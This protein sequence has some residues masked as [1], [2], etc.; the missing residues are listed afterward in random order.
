MASLVMLRK[1]ITLEWLGRRNVCDISTLNDWASFYFYFL[2]HP[3]FLKV[4]TY[5]YFLRDSLGSLLDQNQHFLKMFF[6][7]ILAK[8]RACQNSRKSRK[9][10]HPTTVYVHKY[11]SLQWF[12]NLN[13]ST[14]SVGYLRVVPCF[15]FLTFFLSFKS[16]NDIQ[17]SKKRRVGHPFFSKERSVLCVLL[18]SL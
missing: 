3:D 8:L 18:R 13:I 16:L 5:L 15:V 14:I 9:L 7:E 12:K 17:I 4:R 2:N 1:I 6:L 11:R 10:I